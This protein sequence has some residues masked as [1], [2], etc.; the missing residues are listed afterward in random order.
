MKEKLE[1]LREALDKKDEEITTIHADGV[2]DG[3]GKA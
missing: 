2:I 3:F 1:R